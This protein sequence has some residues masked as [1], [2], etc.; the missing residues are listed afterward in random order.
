MRADPAIAALA[1]LLAASAPAAAQQRPTF[2]PTRDVAVTY[3]ARISGTDAPHAFVLRASAAAGRV[4]LDGELPGYV[5]VDL[6][7]RRASIVMEQLGMML[8]APPNAGLEQALVLQDGRSFTRK[9]T[10]TI[11]GQRCTLWDIVADAASGTACITADGTVL[12]A[13]GQDRKGRT[14]HVVATRVEYGAQPETLFF[15]P[16]NLRRVAIAPGPGLPSAAAVLDRLRGR[17]P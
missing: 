7:A 12:R 13:D 9:G 16:P 5:L 14:G 11:A 4:R 2:P 17:Q 1:V 6:K 10:A 8:D 15:P 3:E